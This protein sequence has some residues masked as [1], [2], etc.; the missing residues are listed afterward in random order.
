MMPPGEIEFGMRGQS[1]KVTFTGTGGG[2]SYAHDR[3]GASVLLENDGGVIL[4]DCGPGVMRRVFRSGVD[5]GEINAVF[6]T[7]LHYGHA[8]GLAEL[9][10]MF[11][12]RRGDPP[13]IFGPRD[14]TEYVEN[15]KKLIITNGMKEL[16]EGLQQL[17][18]QEITPGEIYE[19][20]GFTA[21]AIEVPHDP[22]IQALAWRFRSEGVN[23]VVSG[24]QATDDK[25]MVPFASN[26]DL[27]VHEA[28]TKQGIETQA[29]T[30]QKAERR[31]L[32]MSAF[33][34]AHSDVSAAAKVAEQAGAKRLALTALL[35]TED[36]ALLVNSAREHYSGE[37]F[38]A[39][40]GESLEI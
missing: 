2:G 36:E 29:A 40:P 17:Q 22:L 26:A 30:L 13:R 8:I 19:V 31:A 39:Q 3:G 9:F 11:G 10:N 28:H 37:V 33:P 6:I 34:N 24:D 15:C 12:R 4:I 38:V 20:G 16:P 21:D 25:L 7:H 35:P 1:M 14:I 32:F 5:I 23:V 18:G 27:L